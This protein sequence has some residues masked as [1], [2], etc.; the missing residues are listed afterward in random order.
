MQTIQ[1]VATISEDG[2]LSV[3]GLLSVAPGRYQVVIVLDE[4]DPLSAKR[5]V[6]ELP[7][8]DSAGRPDLPEFDVGEW[9]KDL[10]LRRE[11][12]YDDWGR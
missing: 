10:S 2:T 3:P 8:P 6:L 9:P 4:T 1:T 5:P 12:M 11:D 7:V